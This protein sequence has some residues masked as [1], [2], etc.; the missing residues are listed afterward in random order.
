MAETKEC[1][2]QL[3]N[4]SFRF[5]DASKSHILRVDEEKLKECDRCPLFT[6]C[7]FLKYN[8]MFREVLRLLDESG[9]RVDS[10]P[11]LR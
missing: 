2:G 3:A 1:F 8:D 7:M 9:A 6:K 10:R 4:M 11:R 5:I